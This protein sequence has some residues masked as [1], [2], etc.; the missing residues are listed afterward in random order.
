MSSFESFSAQHVLTVTGFA[1]VVTLAILAARKIRSPER[2]RALE[3]GVAA[4]AAALWIGI[5]LWGFAPGRFDPRWSF[6]IN[7]CDLVAIVVPIAFVRP[8]RNLHALLYFWGFSLSTQAV[9]TPDLVSGPNTLAF[10]VFWL[11]HV[12]IVGGAVYIIVIRGYRPTW[13]DAWFAIAM[14]IVWLVVVF[15][16]NVATGY[17]Y[18]YVGNAKPSQPSLIDYL[19]PWPQRV[20]VM[21]LLG[22]AAMLLLQLPWA[23]VRNRSLRQRHI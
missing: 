23:I 8:H 7:I 15:A 3:S 21:A 2:R 1:I 18:G 19:G 4:L 16:I 10:W 11:L 17:N 22:A 6:P 9:F 5:V 14:A 20:L 12:L 13:R